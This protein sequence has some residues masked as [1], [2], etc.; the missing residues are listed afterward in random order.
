M[1][2]SYKYLINVSIFCIISLFNFVKATT[3]E[4][5]TGTST[6]RQPF[7][8]LYGYE[9][10]AAIYTSTEIGTTGNITSL[11]FNVSSSVNEDCNVKIYLKTTTS[12]TLSASTWA[13]MISGA[14]TVYNGSVNFSS[15]GWNTIALTNSF[16][17]T[18]DNLLVLIETNYTGSGASSYPYFRYTS[19]T[20][21]HKFWNQNTSAPTGNGTVNSNRPNIQITFCSSISSFPWSENFDGVTIPAYPDCW[22]KESGD[23]VTTNNSN[24]TYDADARSGTQFLR[25]TW[26][27]TNEYI[28][29]PGFSLTAGNSYNFS[30]WFGGDNY[31]GWTG[32]VFYN[33]SQSS[34]G[35]TE[36]GSDFITSGITSTKTYQQ[37]TRTYTPS[38]SGT[39]YFAI[40][41]NATSTPYYL[42]F[43][44]FSLTETVSCA[45]PTTQSTNLTFTDIC[46]S[47]ATIGWTRGNGSNCAVF[48]YQGS[49]GTAAPVNGTTYTANTAFG[50]GIQ[51][52]TSGWYCIYNGGGTSVSVTGL[53]ASTAYR[54]QVCEYNC[55]TT[56]TKYNTTSTTNN[57]N[58]FSTTSVPCYCD[59]S[60][61][62]CQ[63]YISRVQLGTIDNSTV[64]T[65]G[66]Y[67][68]YTAQSTN[69]SIGSNYS[70]VV[71]N[72]S[73]GVSDQ[74]GI[75][76]DWNQD[77]DFGDPNETVTVLGTPGAG[78]YTATVAPPA[79][80]TL[81]T[82]RM[83]VRIT[84]TGTLDPC[85]T[86]NYG[87]VEDYSINVQAG[88][89]VTPGAPINVTGTA[90]GLTTA[91]LSWAAGSPTGSA[92]IT[93]YWVVGTSPTV[94]YNSVTTHGYTN[95]T[96]ATIS[97]LLCNT[98]YYLRVYASSSCNGTTSDYTTSATFTTNPCPV[99]PAN[100]Q[101]SGAIALS[102]NS[103]TP[104]TT[105]AAT[106]TGDPTATC[107][108]TITAPGVWYKYTS[109]GANDV[110]VSL[111][112]SALDTKLSIY[113]GTCASLSCITGED[114]DYTI[115]GDNDPSITF[116]SV[117]GTTY[118][119]F[120]HGTGTATG[121]FTINV[122]CSPITLPNCP[123]LNSPSNGATNI[124]T[125][126]SLNWTAPTTGGAVVSYNVY[127]GTSS[128]PP[129]VANV[130]TALTYSPTG[131][132]AGT[133]YYWKVTSVNAAGESSSCTIKRFTTSSITDLTVNNTSYT[134]SYM[135]EHYLISGC[136]E[137]SLV[138]FTGNSRQIGYFQGGS[139]TIGYHSG[140]VLSSGNAK[141][142]EGP[143]SYYN[144][145]TDYSGVD[146][147]ATIDA[148]VSP[149]ESQDAAVLEF[150][151][152]PSSNT[153]SFRYTFASEEYNEW[154]GSTYNDAFGFFLTGGP[155]NYNNKNLALI[156]GTSTPVTINN[157]NNGWAAAD[158]CGT[159]PGSFPTYFRDNACT[160][161]GSYP[162]NIECDGMTTVLTASATVTPCKWY[163]IKLV[164]A[165][166]SDGIYDSWVFLEANSFSSGS[167]VA[168][169]VANPTGTKHSYEGCTSSITFTRTDTVDTSAPINVSYSMGGTTT[170]GTDYTAPQ[171]PVTIPIGVNSVTI[172]LYTNSDG[173]TEGIES[174]IITVT[175]GGCPCNPDIIK[176]TIFLHDFVGVSAHIQE[177]D[178]SICNGASVTLHGVVTAGNYYQYSWSS[179]GGMATVHT[180]NI[181]VS[182]TS[183]TYYYLL[184]RDSCEN[185]ARDTVRIT[186]NTFSS[187]P[188][189][190]T[191]TPSTI[192]N[193]ESTT[194]AVV[195][196]SL[197]TGATWHWY[198]G[199]CGGTAAGTGS[200]ISVSPTTSTT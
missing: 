198:S 83:R 92:T 101:C 68:D 94:D 162:Y 188:T 178:Q 16:G 11:G 192:C 28:W 116:T 138:K 64:C 104:G 156:P 159:G 189:S 172:P 19:S 129:F 65:S 111:C 148:I 72:G 186:V 199:S 88:S 195:G 145:Q 179:S 67:T 154:V 183:T 46:A 174:I 37:V 55:A 132:T 32:D 34:T 181:T 56:N 161:S 105:T 35:A 26:S 15:T 29:T 74:C 4:I 93:Y 18:G 140:I 3:V 200:S 85:G 52:G 40:R 99:I 25:E 59:A 80:S 95:G 196:G 182:P 57:P 115:C 86:T 175:A 177:A 158:S 119:F 49:T 60:A 173:V 126:A 43:D 62:T 78:Q 13:T 121:D 122:T 171:N 20:S 75:W 61:T 130:G 39:Y 90:T 146:G 44:D 21:K 149:Y 103:S 108:T 47:E 137:D 187:I 167:G 63:E 48:M 165:D 73:G 147:D 170:S 112:G 190:A 125:A 135:V 70:I 98:T 139:S 144:N 150:Y 50:S 141:D 41:V 184:V 142:A 114:D 128:N 30:Y 33:T 24:S 76:I 71:T 84:Y 8:M 185:V 77:G 153:V 53:T 127:F 143:N 152:K 69:M 79:S 91:N 10:S 110:T 169:S 5:G 131:M 100:D 2:K 89:C 157:V 123:T 124:G 102:C 136:L 160:V 12:T 97:T 176:D 113:S 23:W 45:A 1:K 87:E 6:Q 96:S 134:A 54:V 17:Y 38:T 109:T 166:V 118:Y 120:V 27:A 151:F 168:M 22:L 133:T 81:G 51:I 7:G 107:G 193:G 66:G 58:N 9:R 197:G 163:H 106:S 42:S 194:L 155:E 191:A 180:Q 14:T 31:S 82:T 36:L 164:V 117:N